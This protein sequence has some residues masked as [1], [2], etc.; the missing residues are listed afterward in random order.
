MVDSILNST[1]K[2]L[3]VEPDD[4]G[5]DTDILMHINTVFTVLNQL[6]IGPDNGF[7]I[8]DDTAVW[9]DFLDPA[10]PLWNSAKTYIYLRV[11]LLFDPPTTSFH[12]ASMEKQIEEL[13]WRLNV[14]REYKLDPLVVVPVPE[15]CD[16]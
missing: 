6:G 12:L 1:K 11:R 9:T 14:Y 7:M 16:F 13:G 4:V 10:D 2:V 5:F 3:G 8:E 15:P